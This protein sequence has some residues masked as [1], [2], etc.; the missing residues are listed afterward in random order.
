MEQSFSLVQAEFD[1]VVDKSMIDTL[2]CGDKAE[3]RVMGMLRE[4]ERVLKPGGIYIGFSLHTGEEVAKFVERLS[5]GVVRD[6]VPC[7]SPFTGG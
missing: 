2:L 1:A 5:W 3:E 4:A 6:K 7:A